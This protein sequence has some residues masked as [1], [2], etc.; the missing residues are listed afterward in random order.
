MHP[1]A[2][3]C[4]ARTSSLACSIPSRASRGA[5]TAGATSRRPSTSSWRWRLRTSR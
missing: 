2:A 4:C 1:S 3:G 5:T